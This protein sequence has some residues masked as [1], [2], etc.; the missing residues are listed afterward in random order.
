MT[1]LLVREYFFLFFSLSVFLCRF[2]VQ[3]FPFAV[4][5]NFTITPRDPARRLPRQKYRQPLD[6]DVIEGRII[7]PCFRWQ[8]DVEYIAGM[9]RRGSKEGE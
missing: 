9:V 2:P 1:L 5:V 7:M 3:R 8:R 4:F 6:R